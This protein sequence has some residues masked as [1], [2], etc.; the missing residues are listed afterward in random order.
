MALPA[1]RRT[2]GR[3]T[4]PRQFIIIIINF[5]EQIRIYFCII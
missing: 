4:A 3:R 1:R 5:F 2:A